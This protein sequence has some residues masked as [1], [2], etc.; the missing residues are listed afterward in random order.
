MLYYD[1]INYKN[2]IIHK[3][4]FNGL[5]DLDFLT[6]GDYLEA[7]GTMRSCWCEE[8]LGEYYIKEII[9]LQQLDAVQQKVVNVYAILNLILWLSEEGVR[10]NSNSSSAI[11]W[12]NVQEKKRKI[13]GLYQSIIA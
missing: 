11:N 5:V 3:G 9:R 10:F 1:D 8:E 4:K 7:I 6:K 13:L 2:V 12:S